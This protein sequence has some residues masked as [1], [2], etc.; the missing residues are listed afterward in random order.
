MNRSFT[1]DGTVDPSQAGQALVEL[2]GKAMVEQMQKAQT[3]GAPVGPYVHGPG[4]LF[5]V[6]GLKRGVISTHT[7][8]TGS[9][10]EMIPTGATG[11]ARDSATNE[12]NPLFPYITGFL[13]SD[14]QEKDGVCD[15]PPEAAGMKTC[16]MTAV[17]GRKEFKTRQIEVNHVGQQINRGEFMDLQ[18]ENSPLVNQMGGLMQS[19]MGG[20]MGNANAILAGR[21]MVLRMVEVG[22]AFQRWFC[23]QVFTGNPSNSAAGGGY[24]EFAGLD[25][26]IGRNKV[27][28]L[29]GTACPSLYSDVKDFNYKQVDSSTDPTLIKTLTTMMHILNRKAIQ[30]NLSPVDF[31]LVMRSELFYYLT[32]IWACNYQTY[33][34]FN[35]DGANID[36][37]GSFSVETTIRMKEDM[38]NGSYLLIDGRKYPVI[39][40]DCIMEESTS[41][42][43]A[44]PVGCYSSDIYI[45]PFA[46][47]GGTLRTLYWEYYDYNAGPMEAIRDIRGTNYFWTGAGV[48]LWGVK[49]P[50]NWCIEAISKVEPRLILRTPQ[51][52][53]RLQNVT[54]CPLQHTDDV[55]PSQPY[56]TDGGVATGYPGPSPYSEWNPSGPGISA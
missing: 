22:V 37:V 18:L 46:A 53:G 26:L 54:Y 14:Q 4:G 52:A 35:F 1:L 25:L 45:V 48:F 33:R 36:P 6:R 41:D 49:P 47:R 24:K 19:F 39:Q 20:S 50:A 29:S 21:E 34:C 7:Q 42:N 11:A 13:R 30:Q 56:W 12:L 23:P 44:I 8:I 55:L 9:L 5:G 43:E 31:R 27:D 51:L 28:A 10:G 3:V 16:I 15:D 2:L 32:E 38:R 17:F 40:D